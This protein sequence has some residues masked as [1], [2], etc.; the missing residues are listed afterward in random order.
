MRA[1]TKP[2]VP[3][4]L[5]VTTL[6]A[7]IIAGAPA[8]KA[9]TCP[10]VA[11]P[12]ETPAWPPRAAGGEFDIAHFGEAHYNEGQGP[13]T[14][15]ILVQDLI[16]YEPDLV[17]FSSDMA[18]I[19][20]AERLLCFRELMDPLVQSGI[21]WF[22]APGNHDRLTVA[23][24][25]GGVVSDGIGPWRETFAA[26]PA[27]W[28]DGPAAG[29]GFVLATG[30]PD[31]GAG[32][33]THYYFD[34]G[35]VGNPAVRMI[36]LDNSRHSFTATDVDQYPAVGPGARDASQLAFFERAASGAR[37]RGL[38]TFALF[39]EPTRDPRDQT[40][41]HP[42]SYNHSMA[43]G[44]TADNQLFDALAVATGTDAVLLGH[45]LGNFEYA[46][47]DV[48]YFI[49]GGAGGSPYTREKTGTDSGYFYA[50]RLLRVFR[51]GAQWSYRTYVVPLVD[52]IELDAPT[53]TAV[54]GTL[55]LTATAVQP[56]DPALPPRFPLMPNAAIRVALRAP[57]P[58][59][60]DGEAVPPVAYMWS[61]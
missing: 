35:P 49:D 27:P 7:A 4:V 45:I 11:A 48:R 28:G 44:A 40:A 6:A 16:A 29:P 30:E 31:D 26:M 43:K 46:V 37:D 59:V 33:A 53:T 55:A 18:D 19:G 14:V 12:A 22:D 52:R 24:T 2:T 13:V 25:F 57:M 54:G 20:T 17:S 39:H 47:S 60:L 61:T 23:N 10:A 21:P 34:Y 58:S 50:Y 3:S 41:A 15:P 1:R 51:D 9:A 38:L 32:A 56:H 8:S 42:I 5:A 36:A